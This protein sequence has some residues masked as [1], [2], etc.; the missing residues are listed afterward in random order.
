[1]KS[2][3]SIVSYIRLITT[4]TLEEKIMNLQAFKLKMANTV[5]SHENSCLETMGTDQLIDLFSVDDSK[6]RAGHQDSITDTGDNKQSTRG[7]KS[8]IESLPDLWDENSYETEYDLSSFIKSL[9]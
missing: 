1:M 6:K 2:D 5:I 9:K 7:I 4:G 3:I 8:I